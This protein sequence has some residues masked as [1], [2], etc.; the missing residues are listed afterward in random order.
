MKFLNFTGEDFDASI[1]DQ[2]LENL[3]FHSGDKR[4]RSQTDVFA[5]LANARVL[6]R[7]PKWEAAIR[8]DEREKI[9]SGGVK[10]TGFTL[11][12]TGW[13]FG[14]DSHPCDTHTA[15]LINITPISEGG[16]ER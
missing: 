10:M 13:S 4:I 3:P 9:L 15:T 5:E 7:I 2:E 1:T 8:A 11:Q 16:E 6:V 12:D 14:Q